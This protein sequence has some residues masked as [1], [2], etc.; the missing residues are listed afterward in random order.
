MGYFV[1][2]L[3]S[4]LVMA[5]A[6]FGDYVDP[7]FNCPATTTCPQ[8]CVETVQSCPVEMRC[9]ANETLCFDGSCA[10]SCP[11]ELES[12]CQFDCASVA[13]PKIVT[14]YDSC[15]SKYGSLYEQ[16]A[17]CGGEE[18]AMNAVHSMKEPAFV[19]M[20][21]WIWVT[22]CLIVAWCAYNQRIAPVAGSTQVL[23]DVHQESQEA[24]SWQTGYKIH[25]IGVTIYAMTLVTL[26][27]FH[28]IL[29]Y[30]V[31]TLLFFPPL[32]RTTIV[33]H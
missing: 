33:A 23:L 6:E 29:A 27:G 20:F 5:G 16:E 28:G 32:L 7:T 1:G 15:N 9:Q 30:L 25:P 24:T 17:A 8:V 11:P 22:T 12:P 3:A 13:C 19:S 21:V 2:L 4:I 10:M 14:D 31:R 18:E 26:F